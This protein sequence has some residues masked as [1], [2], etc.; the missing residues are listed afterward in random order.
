MPEVALEDRHGVPIMK[1]EIYRL[2]RG[3]SPVSSPKDGGG[4]QTSHWEMLSVVQSQQE[5]PAGWS[6]S[7]AT[8]T[9][10]IGPW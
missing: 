6:D 3:N 7:R 5:L 4:G 1:G 9:V 2:C 8:H 10:N